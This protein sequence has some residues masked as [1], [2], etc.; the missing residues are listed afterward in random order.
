M[1]RACR[2]EDDSMVTQGVTFAAKHDCAA[3][4]LGSVCTHAMQ[5]AI[6]VSELL[7]VT[8]QPSCKSMFLVCQQCWNGPVSV[9][10]TNGAGWAHDV[11]GDCRI[12]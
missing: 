9:L 1:S 3:I 7:P 6:S 11:V 5:K 4:L 10:K 8:L 2:Y 12:T